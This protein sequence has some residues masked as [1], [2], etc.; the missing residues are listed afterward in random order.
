LSSC[1][2][3]KVFLAVF[4]EFQDLMSNYVP[5]YSSVAAVTAGGIDP[6]KAKAAV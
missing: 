5:S 6:P 1:N 3:L 2:R 4:K